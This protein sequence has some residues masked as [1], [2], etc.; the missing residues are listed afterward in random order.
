MARVGFIATGEIA[1][2]MVRGLAGCGHE[3]LVSD[4]NARIAANLST[5]V[6]GVAVAANPDV[7]ASSDIVV[8]CLRAEVADEVLLPLPF[9]KGQSVIS[10]MLGVGLNR[11]RALCAPATDI[12]V[13]IPMPGIERGG[14]PLPVFPASP[15]LESLYGSR[16]LIMP[17]SS[18]TALNAHFSASALAAPLLATMAE[19]AEWLAGHTNDVDRA[20]AYVVTMVRSLLAPSPEPSGLAATLQTL[21]T[22]GG[23]N[24]S[25]R[26]R[27]DPARTELRRGLDALAVCLGLRD[28]PE[29]E[30]PD[31]KSASS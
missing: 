15:A 16:N 2:A 19:T 11:L 1:A 5:E 12:A 13:T 21:S 28:T 3:I 27:M 24:A 7:V 9:R 20:E 4:R 14:C 25:L 18:E 10:V 23:L 22:E 29:D 8:L 30:R 6:Y 17:V 31:A 26:D